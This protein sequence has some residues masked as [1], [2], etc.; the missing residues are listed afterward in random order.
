MNDQFILPNTSHF[1]RVD[2]G[3]GP[4]KVEG[5]FG[6]DHHPYP[7]VDQIVDFDSPPWPIKD[8][9]FDVIYARHIIEH[10]ASIPDFMGE[11]HRIGRDKGLVQI[12]TPHFSSINSWDDPTHRWHLGCNWSSIFTEQYLAAQFP[13]F[14]HVST[15]LF[16]AP[17]SLNSLIAKTII[18]VKSRQWWEKNCAF[19]VRARNIHT[20]L[21]IIKPSNS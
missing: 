3:C 8:S 18:K 11:I 16:F 9:S 20:V 17:N 1:D 13:K 21:R 19:V 5:C 12:I 15:D 2:L 10:V 4:A 7:G 14:E 6:V